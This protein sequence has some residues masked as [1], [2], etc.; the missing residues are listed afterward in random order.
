MTRFSR[1]A[2]PAAL[3]LLGCSSLVTADDLPGYPVDTVVDDDIGP[4]FPRLVVAPPGVAIL[5]EYEP[6]LRVMPRPAAPMPLPPPPPIV[7]KEPDLPRTIAIL[8]RTGD[9]LDQ[10]L[11]THLKPASTDLP[12]L[13]KAVVAR[14][15]EAFL[16]RNPDRLLARVTLT[17]PAAQA[18]DAA[19][20]APASTGDDAT[21]PVG[22]PAP[23]PAD[24]VAAIGSA[25][26]KGNPPPPAA[27]S[28]EVA[29]LTPDMPPARDA[30]PPGD[31][32]T[33]AERQ[34]AE[35]DR[36]GWI[37]YRR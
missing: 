29:S 19:P 14:N 18:P 1:F 13:R 25:V 4:A 8:T 7:P 5:P 11:R 30:R 35:A 37:Q 21:A 3:C 24:R 9:T 15:P 22:V 32:E 16:H 6:A 12:A 27:G 31:T 36:S 34:T 28:G 20:G 33:E 17:L 10:I 23:K 2:L 26:E